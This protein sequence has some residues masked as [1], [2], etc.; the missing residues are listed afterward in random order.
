MASSRNVIAK[1]LFQLTAKRV[2]FRSENILSLS[3]AYEKCKTE[4]CAP[5]VDE[6]L[7]TSLGG[8]G[9]DHEVKNVT[10]GSLRVLLHCYTEE[11]LLKIYDDFKSGKTKERLEMEFLTIGIKTE[12]LEVKIENIGE[13]EEKVFAIR[14]R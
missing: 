13:V 8:E 6:K 14:K 2:T 1:F 11:R 7:S 4:S 9:K 3:A 10:E 12:G 5:K